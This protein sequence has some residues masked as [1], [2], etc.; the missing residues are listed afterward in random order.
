MASGRHFDFFHAYA[1]NLQGQGFR[2]VDFATMFKAI[3]EVRFAG[4]MSAAV[5]DYA[6]TPERAARESVAS[7]RRIEADSG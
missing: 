4:W 7:I 2:A 1:V 3:N 5:F 6:P